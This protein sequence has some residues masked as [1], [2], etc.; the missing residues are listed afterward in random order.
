MLR[1]AQERSVYH[2]ETERQYREVPH[3]PSTDPTL[4]ICSDDPYVAADPARVIDDAA[5]KTSGSK[6]QG[7]APPAGECTFTGLMKCNPTTFHRNE[8]AMELC[9]R[10]KKTERLEVSNE[11]PWDEMKTLMKEEFCPPEDIQRMEI[12]LW[13]LRVK[14]SNIAAYTQ[15]FNEL[16]LLCS[17]AIPSEKKKIKAYI[18]GLLENVKGETTSSK[19]T[20]LNEA[21]RMA[22]TMTKQKL[23]VKVERVAEGNKRRDNTRHHQYNQRRQSNAK[24][25]TT[26]QNEGANQT[27]TTPKLVVWYEYE[28]RDHKSNKFSKR[29]NQRGGNAM[30]RAYAMRDAEQNPSPNVVTGMFLLNNRYARVLFD[31]GSDKSFVNTSFSHLIDIEPV[32]QNTRYEVELANRRRVST[33]TVLR[34]YTLNLVNHLFEIDLMPIELCT[35]DVII[36]MDWL[37]ARDAVIVCGK[38][39]VHIPHKNKTL[40]VKGDGSTSQLKVISCI[41]V[42]KYIE[43][44]CHLFLAQVTEKEPAEKRLEDVPVIYDFPEVF[45]DDLPG[46]PPPSASGIQN[47]SGAWSYTC[48]PCTVPISTIKD[49]GVIESTARV[50]GERIHPPELFT[51]GSY[52][53]ICEEEGCSSVY[54]KIDLRSGYHQLRIREE[55]I[56][57]TAFQTRYGHY[58]FQ[59]MSFGL[60]NTPEVFMDLMNHVCKPYLD[61]FVIVFIDDILIYS[62]NKKE[63]E[64]H[65]KTILQLHKKEKLYANFSKCDFWLDSVQFLG[66][67]ID[68][69]GIHRFIEGFSLIAKP[70]TKLTH[71]NKKYEWGEE[72]EEAFQMLKQ[73]LCSAPILALPDETKDF[74]YQ[75]ELNMRQR[76]WIK[77][78]SDYDCEILYHPGKANVVADALSRKE[79]GIPLRVRS[80]VMTLH[81]DLPGRILIAQTE[82]MKKEIVK[83]ESLGRL[84]K[85]IF[86]IR[87]D[88]I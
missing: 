1:S 78:L 55:D 16:D 45:F 47:R 59:V 65:L 32:R 79:R 68:S 29:I 48:C 21:V 52:D 11:K 31:S 49:K 81:T 35:F 27:G 54:S 43:R 73:K 3:D 46:L 2:H 17:E 22:H 37:V 57:I 44:G 58:E 10:F 41:K 88:G 19:P 64:E 51:L 39:V 75:K 13:N 67:V 12:E 34:G 83:P 42:R 26:A 30:G 23:H 66:H 74:L 61:M 5:G 28:E 25:M 38:K 76:R 40:V 86:E 4:L 87:S 36:G 70:L 62:K 50:V 85:P 84:I 7:G 18:H 53:V 56:P 15:R 24:A 71:K 14:D 8:G 72:E 63:H 20:T 6:G 69:K 80:L 60:T 33:N 82:A 9:R 77:L